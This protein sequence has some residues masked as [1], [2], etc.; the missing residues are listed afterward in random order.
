MDFLEDFFGSETARSWVHPWMPLQ[1]LTPS[2][3][4]FLAKLTPVQRMKEKNRYRIS[5][6]A[7]HRQY[8]HRWRTPFLRTPFP[9]LLVGVTGML[10][11]QE[12]HA[13]IRHSK[14]GSWKVLK[15]AFEKIL[16]RFLS[17]VDFI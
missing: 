8:A 16:G 13:T 7:P 9:R 1:S 17:V 4:V 15:I 2:V 3:L 12:D 11:N 10:T 5:V 6:S 14:K